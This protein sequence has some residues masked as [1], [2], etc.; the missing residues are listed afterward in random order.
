[1]LLSLY[2]PDMLSFDEIGYT[3]QRGAEVEVEVWWQQMCL[4]RL[5]TR[6]IGPVLVSRICECVLSVPATVVKDKN[7][8]ELIPPGYVV[9][10]RDTRRIHASK[11]SG[12]GGLVATDVSLPI[13]HKVDW[14]CVGVEDLWVRIECS[15]YGG[16]GVYLCCVYLP[17]GDDSTLL[18]FSSYVSDIINNN[19]DSAFIILGDFNIPTTEWTV[20]AQDEL[21]PIHEI[22]FRSKELG[23]FISI[24]SVTQHNS[25]KNTNN[26]ILDLVFSNHTHRLA[27]VS[28]GQ[29]LVPED[30]HP[31]IEFSLNLSAIDSL[32]I[33]EGSVYDFK[34]A[35]YIKLKRLLALV[36]WYGEL[37]G[38]D[39]T[40]AASK[41]CFILYSL[42]RKCGP[43]NIIKE[44]KYP[45]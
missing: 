27:R 29:P 20:S 28:V 37:T 16:Q 8:A 39:A 31:T 11:R 34:R 15:G 23:E 25:V 2:L 1:M 35:N 41:F 42:Y 9:F 3:R 18:L 21:R 5:P 36:D 44:H 17:S 10:R 22:S 4:C 40:A 43:V 33:R 30:H 32:K 19:P 14:S 6:S 13:T 24:C 12:G 26:R 38:I 45:I 7:V